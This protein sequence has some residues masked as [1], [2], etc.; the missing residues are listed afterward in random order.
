M[1]ACAVA[2]AWRLGFSPPPRGL[3]GDFA[4]LLGRASLPC[5]SFDAA[6][7]S[8]S[9]RVGS[10][11]QEL[12]QLCSPPPWPPGPPDL[13]RRRTKLGEVFCFFFLFFY[14]L[15]FWFFTPNIDRFFLAAVVILED[16]FPVIIVGYCW[17]I[18]GY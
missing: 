14:F 11:N 18:N 6:S 4:S 15:V 16:D 5:S 3:G 12:C 9:P 1:L 8:G 13:L 17:I 7:S 10:G 2:G